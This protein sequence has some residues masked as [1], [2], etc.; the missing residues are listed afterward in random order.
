M[1]YSLDSLFD[2]I[3]S[4]HEKVN[5]LSPSRRW[6]GKFMEK[7]KYD[8]TY[9]SNKLEGNT[10]TYGETISF[11]KNITVPRKSQKDLL[12][13]ENHFKVLDTVFEQYDKPFSVEF[14]KEVHKTL[15]KDYDQWEYEA[16]PNPGQFK[17]FEN[18]AILPSG[19]IKEYMKPSEVPQALN[20]LIAD[21]NKGLSQMDC[22]DMSKHP[23]TIA[24]LFHNRFLNEIHPFQDGNGRIGRIFTNMILLKS[25]F[26]PIFLETKDNIEREKYLLT[27]NESEVKKDLRPMVAYLG[28]KLVESLERKL[29]YI[30]K[31]I[32]NSQNLSK[33]KGLSL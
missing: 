6:D 19:K 31:A 20:E 7:V 10:L 3:N 13:I 2:K 16:L 27:I 5:A 9:H 26:P 28:D 4:L 22:K 1:E 25:D 18:Y 30:Q 21:T 32:N 29:S 15:M 23:L 8:F 11:L 12:D 33:D 14:I 24:S 17:M